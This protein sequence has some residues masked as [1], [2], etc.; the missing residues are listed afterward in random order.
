MMGYPTS[1]KA[2]ST[3]HLIIACIA[4][5]SRSSRKDSQPLPTPFPPSNKFSLAR[6][7][8]RVSQSSGLISGCLDLIGHSIP[9]DLSLVKGRFLEAFSPR[10]RQGGRVRQS[11]KGVKSAFCFLSMLLQSFEL[12]GEAL[13]LSL[14]ALS[15]ANRPSS[16]MR[17]SLVP[18]FCRSLR[19]CARPIAG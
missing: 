11:G 13:S 15:S 1:C 12:F 10:V 14:L 2:R 6:C 19:A 18:P 9:P 4:L 5:P 8:R 17:V 3:W 16:P 7:G